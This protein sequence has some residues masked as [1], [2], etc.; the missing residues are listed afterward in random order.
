MSILSPIASPAGV[1]DG[2]RHQT[3]ASTLR[4]LEWDD[5]PA[6]VRAIS[7][8]FNPLADGILMLHQRQVAALKASIIAIP[9]GRRTG[10]TF[11]T[12]LNK[13]LVAAARKSAGG[14]NVYYIGDTKRA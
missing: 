13:T 5:L 4:V 9:K 2:R 10:I 12:M 3:L 14:D 8:S 7:D 6:S 1:A 11:G